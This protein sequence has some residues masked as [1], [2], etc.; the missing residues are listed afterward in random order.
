MPG[1]R[2]LLGLHRA[3]SQGPLRPACATKG[4]MSVQTAD[5][6]LEGLE[7]RTWC[8]RSSENARRVEKSAGNKTVHTVDVRLRKKERRALGSEIGSVEGEM[9]R[10][11]VAGAGR[12]T[13]RPKFS[14]ESGGTCMTMYDSPR[15]SSHRFTAVESPSSLPAIAAFTTQQHAPDTKSFRPRRLCFAQLGGVQAPFSVW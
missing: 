14:A 15:A 9:Q 5:C 11:S 8:R 3:A 13:S 6:C 12:N 1:L 4:V 2:L 10:G 7:A